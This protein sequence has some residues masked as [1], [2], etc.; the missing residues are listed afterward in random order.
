MSEPSSATITIIDYIKM[1]DLEVICDDTDLDNHQFPITKI[2]WRLNRNGEVMK[3]QQVNV[4]YVNSLVL[5]NA[6]LNSVAPECGQRFPVWA[7]V[8]DSRQCRV[9]R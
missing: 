6:V 4:D 9:Q 7:K 3:S 2:S 8:K 1:R 5:T